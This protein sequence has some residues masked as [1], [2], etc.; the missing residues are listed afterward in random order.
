MIGLYEYDNATHDECVD[1]LYETVNALQND[2][3]FG[4]PETLE[5][6]GIRIQEIAKRLQELED[7]AK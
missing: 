4:D 3:W 2:D 7:N 5:R 1:D 6:R